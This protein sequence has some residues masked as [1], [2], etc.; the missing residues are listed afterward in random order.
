MVQDKAAKESYELCLRQRLADML[1]QHRDK[2]LVNF[3]QRKKR[4]KAIAE[5]EQRIARGQVRH[6][7]SLATGPFH[8]RHN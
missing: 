5:L 1:S 7:L 4:V 6:K 2:V 3:E 8:C